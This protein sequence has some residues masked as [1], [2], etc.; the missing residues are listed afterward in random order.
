MMTQEQWELLAVHSVA[1]FKNL[2]LQFCD[3]PLCQQR[4]SYPGC[5]VIGQPNCRKMIVLEL[6][7]GYDEIIGSDSGWNYGINPP[8]QDPARQPY[9]ANPDSVAPVFF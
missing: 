4:S 2:F 5:R 8:F 1:G 9:S 3:G 7:G 6:V